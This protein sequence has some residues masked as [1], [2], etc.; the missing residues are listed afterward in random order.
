MHVAT[1]IVLSAEETYDFSI[2]V[3]APVDSKV[4]VKPHPDGNDNEFLYA[5]IVDFAADGSCFYL[6]DVAGFDGTLVLTLDFA[7][8]PDTDFE[9]SNIV[10]KKHSDDD[11]TVLPSEPDEPEAPVTWVDV[12]SEDNMFF[13]CEYTTEFYYAPGMGADCRP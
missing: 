12:N 9:I 5:D 8:N 3:N 2:F 4:T 6:S 13:G 1:D 10:I 7:G 11:G